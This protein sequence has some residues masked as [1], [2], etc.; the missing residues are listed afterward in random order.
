MPT[1]RIKKKRR[2][3]K[4]KALAERLGVIFTGVV[5]TLAGLV[6]VLRLDGLTINTVIIE[7]EEGVLD[8]E[9]LKE[10]IN[11]TL[12]G[13]YVFLPKR[14]IFIFPK[15]ELERT[16]EIKF[17]RIGSVEIERDDLETLRIFIEE[18]EPTAL[19][20]GEEPEEE[21]ERRCFYVDNKGIIYS[22]APSFSGDVFF[23]YYGGDV[24]IKDPLMSEVLPEEKMAEMKEFVLHLQE[25]DLDPGAAFIK[26]EEFEIFLGKDSKLYLSNYESIE[27]SFSRLNNLIKGS[28][29]NFISDQGPEFS[30]IDLRF[31]K[32]VFYKMKDDDE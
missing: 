10:Q 21:Q 31:G 8:F 20:C 17:P 9:D 30:Y 18:R 7:N 29:T 5:I 1:P 12:S 24:G 32:R 3:A 19:W 22:K 14:N 15:D 13:S 6:F 11:E 28:E 16:L 23:R 25:M 4:L 26:E 2:K 27:E